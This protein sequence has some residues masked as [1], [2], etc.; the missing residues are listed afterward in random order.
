V[1]AGGIVA[2]AEHIQ[3]QAS[4]SNPRTIVRLRKDAAANSVSA[5]SIRAVEPL[6]NVQRRIK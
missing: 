3:G 1:V 5:G 6:A 2:T 4:G